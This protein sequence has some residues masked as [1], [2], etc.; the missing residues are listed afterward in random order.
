MTEPGRETWKVTPTLLNP[1]CPGHE[2]VFW[3]VVI[4]PGGALFGGGDLYTKKVVT[5]FLPEPGNGDQVYLWPDPEDG[6]TGGPAWEVKRRYMASDGIWH[7]ELAAM[8]IDP[9]EQVRLAIGEEIIRG[10]PR[11][12]QTWWTNTDDGDP[13]P[14]LQA[15]GW[16]RYGED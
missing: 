9:T 8:V 3:L 2:V 10:G 16:K 6:A 1:P 14:K 15:G 13:T 7:V 11:Q 12:F 4:P 5:G